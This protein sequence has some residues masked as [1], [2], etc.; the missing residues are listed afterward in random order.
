[1]RNIL[2]KVFS[3]LLLLSVSVFVLVSCDSPIYEKEDVHVC[4]LYDNDI[5]Y[6]CSS[7]T[8][9]VYDAKMVGEPVGE[10]VI[11]RSVSYKGKKFAVTGIYGYA[12]ENCKYLN[13]VVIPDL[14]TDLSRNA[15]RGCDSLTIYCEAKEKPSGWHDDWNSSNCPVVWDCKNNDVA[16]DG[17]AYSVTDG[18]RYKL[19]DDVAIVDIQPKHIAG[20]I[21]IPTSITYKENVYAVKCI[22]S[23]AFKDCENLESVVIEEG[24][25]DVGGSVFYNCY[26]LKSAIFPNSVEIIG[27]SVFYCCSSLKIVNFPSKETTIGKK[28]FCGCSELEQFEIPSQV[29]TIDDSAFGGCTSL[30]SIKIPNSVEHMGEGVF[31]ACSALTTYVEAVQK[32][33]GWDDE[34]HRFYPIVWDCNNNQVADD[35]Y[36]YV[37]IDG[38]RYRFKDDKLYFSKQPKCINELI[39]PS[40][41][42]YN[43]K[44]YEIE[45]ITKDSINGCQ[46]LTSITIP[47]SVKRISKYAI[48]R[49]YQLETIYYEGTIDEWSRIEKVDE[50]VGGE[51]PLK[52]IICTDG[53]IEFS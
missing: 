13:K 1:M 11:P 15:F 42:T 27:E 52:K 2:L 18:V 48:Y 3:C 51:T 10:V 17:Y 34:W 21:I 35:G 14:V 31:N 5:A 45:A 23:F 43:G 24:V 20:D 47:T 32:P 30:T 28:F 46:K 39:I 29:H 26:S 9:Y 25:T 38:L 49:C 41:V 36:I 33:S 44:V 12:F 37:M 53:E 4:I 16:D 19:K 6:L 40:S 50:W 22:E 8:A 7:D